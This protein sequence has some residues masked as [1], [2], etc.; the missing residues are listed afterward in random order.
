ML[1]PAQ[2]AQYFFISVCL[3]VRLCLFLIVFQV[4]DERLIS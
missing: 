4:N 1:L 2:E 3:F